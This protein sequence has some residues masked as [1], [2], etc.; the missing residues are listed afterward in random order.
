LKIV[1]WNCHGAF[2]KKYQQ[3][4]YLNADIYVI[5]ECE[6]PKNHEDAF[7]RLGFS[8]SYFWCGKNDNRGIAGFAFDNIL[9]KENLWSKDCLK[10]FI[11]LKINN[12]FD[13]LCVWAC[14]PYIEEYFQYQDTNFQHYSNDM[15]IIGDFNSN[16][17]WDKKYSNRNHTNVVSSLE[18]IGLVSAYHHLS[19]ELQGKE[20]KNTFYLHYK[21]EKGYHIDYCFIAPEKLKEFSILDSKNWLPYSDHIPI[22]VEIKI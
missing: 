7:K 6:N 3:L 4:Q 9:L 2:R 18:K 19:K 15:I 16:A 5:Q 14:A 11:S 13:L 1:S 17:K 8:G 22:M 20:S 12:S 10:H 21:M